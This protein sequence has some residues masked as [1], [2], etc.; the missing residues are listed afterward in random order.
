MQRLI[1]LALLV[2]GLTCSLPALTDTV[3]TPEISPAL[4]MNALAII[5]GGLLILRSRRTK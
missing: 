4:G 5:T 3:V 2:V 1:A